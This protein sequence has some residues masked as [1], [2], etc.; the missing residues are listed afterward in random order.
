M[1]IP[2]YHYSYVQY[3]DGRIEKKQ[4]NTKEEAHEYNSTMLEN[5]DVVSCWT[6]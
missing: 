6:D 5:P 2:S 3:K 1:N 4:F